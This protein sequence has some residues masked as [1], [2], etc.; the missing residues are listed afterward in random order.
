M[1]SSAAA[2]V[3]A[4]VD[5]A[6]EESI[7]VL[8]EAPWKTFRGVLLLQ[9]TSTSCDDV[10]C[11]SESLHA[12]MLLI[13]LCSLLVLVI[14]AFA[15][16][17]EDKAEQITPLCPQLVAKD[18]EITFQLPFGDDVNQFPVTDLNGF[19][20]CKV[21]VDWSDP[22]RAGTG[23]VAATVRLISNQNVTLATV[24]ARNVA[25]VGQ[26]L[27]LLR[28]GHEIFGFVEPDGPRCYNVKH[29]TGVHLLTLAGDFGIPDVEGANPVGSKVCWSK[30]TSD[31]GGIVHGGVIQH[32]DA[33]LFICAL[34]ATH[35]HRRL[36]LGRSLP[37]SPW[38]GTEDV[39]AARKASRVCLSSG[40]ER[41]PTTARAKEENDEDVWQA[42]AVPVDQPSTSV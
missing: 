20:L 8:K 2:A 14:C 34:M 17:R 4:A 27:A 6:N 22:F 18:S 23:G 13:L 5:A 1:P 25:V 37:S 41:E 36:S 29:R 21:D 32:V 38:H 30:A 12:L 3:A 11:R 42:E 7:A 26:G 9:A 35:L 24:I 40:E 15:F 10:D 19:T 33:G 31:N 28:A 39:L 16:F